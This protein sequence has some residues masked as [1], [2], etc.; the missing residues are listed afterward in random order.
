MPWSAF[1]RDQSH[2]KDERMPGAICRLPGGTAPA[3]EREHEQE[4]VRPCRAA[5]HGTPHAERLHPLCPFDVPE[6]P[7]PGFVPIEFISVT[8]PDPWH[9]MGLGASAAVRVLPECK[10]RERR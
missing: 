10:R 2:A 9:A 7:Q 4:Q 6:L 5:T 3:A 1:R 8:A